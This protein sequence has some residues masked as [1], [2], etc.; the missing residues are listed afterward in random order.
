[1]MLPKRLSDFSSW[2]WWK[3]NRESFLFQ[4]KKQL[5]DFS[6]K[7]LERILAYYKKSNYQLLPILENHP[8]PKFSLDS[9]ALHTS[10]TVSNHRRKYHY[11]KIQYELIEEHHWWRIEREH[12]LL[13]PGIVGGFFYNNVFSCDGKSLYLT[14][15]ENLDRP[16]K[17][18]TTHLTGP[19]QKLAVGKNNPFY[20]FQYTKYTSS[21]DWEIGLNKIKN[22]N[23]KCI[24]ISPSQIQ[25]IWFSCPGFRF[26]CP[27]VVSGEVLNDATRKIG[28]DIFTKLIDKMRCWDG[29]LGFYECRHGRK[30]I[31]DE[32][33]YVEQISDRLVST[34]YY[35][36][37]HPFLKYSNGDVGQLEED[38]CPCGIY[39]RY[40]TA[41]HGRVNEAILLSG[42]W[43]PGDS[44]KQEIV[45]FLFFADFNSKEFSDQFFKK[46][47]S[48]LLE[49]LEIKWMLK[50]AKDKSLT[51]YCGSQ[52][53]P[54]QQSYYED[55]MN[56]IILRRVP[57][58]SLN[59]KDAFLSSNEIL[60]F[61]Y[62]D[63]NKFPYK[64]KNL[65]V[66]SDLLNT[67]IFFRNLPN[68]DDQA[69]N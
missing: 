38:L 10:G 28:N 43:L 49:G 17:D 15:G 24:Y 14:N 63:F 54:Q 11:P 45:N 59:I 48:N 39:G 2:N 51:L 60:N 55:A 18:A 64:T 8:E 58:M 6:K 5:D 53:T 40:I 9:V 7:S 61:N 66:Q 36:Y 37:C 46:H 65:M 23:P 42:K 22:L 34:D 16:I 32:L 31:Y 19:V 44:I 68:L 47:G 33:S 57:G 56:F 41:I 4:N 29:G 1:M 67:E 26:N 3:K 50:Q 20:Q 25:C 13:L 62:N 30:H 52:L 35:N 27:A 69:N 12:N 21:Q